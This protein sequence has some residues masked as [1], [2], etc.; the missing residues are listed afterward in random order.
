MEVVTTFIIALI[1]EQK[2]S[3]FRKKPRE[4]DSRVRKR[5]LLG[6]ALALQLLDSVLPK[7]G[8][9]FHPLCSVK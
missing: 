5:T 9:A 6:E 7:V 3:I 4:V 1:G 2:K 8:A